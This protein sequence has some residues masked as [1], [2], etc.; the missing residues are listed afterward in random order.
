MKAIKKFFEIDAKYKSTINT[1]ERVDGLCAVISYVLVMAVYYAM[2]VIY[3]EKNLYLGY[4]I[5]FLLVVGCI[6]CTLLRRQTMESIGF[7]KRNIIK[8]IL[9]GMITGIIVLLINLIPGL[10]SGRQFNTI[11]K[12]GSLFFYYFIIIALVEEV[13]FRGFI[14]TRIYGIVKRPLAAILLT[15]LM[16]MTIHIPFQM[17]AA[18]MDF[19]TYLSNNFVTL[20]FT[21][22]WHIILN[23]LYSKYNSIAAPMIFHTL[24]DW[25]NYLFIR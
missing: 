12:L 9:L 21:F 1:Y 16:F 13:I 14:Q 24:M 25:S 7:G 23:F 5:N 4:Q 15:A 17:G 22:I 20:I 2:G 10:I 6:A 18:H 19:I 8:S 3:A 11:S